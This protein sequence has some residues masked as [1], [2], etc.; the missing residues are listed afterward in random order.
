[1]TEIGSSPGIDVLALELQPEPA[2]ETIEE[3]MA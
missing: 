1:M 3:A 2:A